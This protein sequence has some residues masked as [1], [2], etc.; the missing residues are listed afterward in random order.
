M[1]YL[2][3]IFDHLGQYIK[4]KIVQ[5]IKSKLTKKNC[6]KTAVLLSAQ[7]ANIEFD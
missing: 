2:T 4:I 5:P 3:F 7:E 6:V 1:R